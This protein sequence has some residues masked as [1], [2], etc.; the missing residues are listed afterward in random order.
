MFRYLLTYCNWKL[1]SI[2]T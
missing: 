2:I 1:F